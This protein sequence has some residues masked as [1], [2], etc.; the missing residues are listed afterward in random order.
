MVAGILGHYSLSGRSI[1]MI[2]RTS[3][4]PWQPKGPHIP[5]RLQQMPALALALAL[6]VLLALCL[7]LQ[8]P[9]PLLLSAVEARDR[10]RLATLLKGTDNEV[11]QSYLGRTPLHL[12]VINDA[13]EMAAMLI[14]AGAGLDAPDA[15]GNTP[16]HLAVFCH[17]PD[18]VA[19]L[20]KAGAGINL[21]NRFGSTPLHVGAFVGAPQDIMQELIRQGADPSL[22]DGRGRTPMDIARDRGR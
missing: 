7:A 3:R 18:M 10:Q 11:N 1:L 12:A 19:L 2:D 4:Q 21:G 6:L 5:P 22:K 13:D 17:R 20:L 14:A 15:Y 8:P 16:L 9:P